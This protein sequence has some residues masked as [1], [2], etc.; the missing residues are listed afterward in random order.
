LYNYKTIEEKSSEWGITQRHIQ[1][2][3]RKGLIA[4]AI[5]RAGAW[6]IPDETP[7][8]VKNTRAGDKPFMFVGTK[9]LIFNSSI[10]L[11]T[12]KG[13]EN[14]SMN[15]ITAAIGVRQSAVYNHFKSKHE[16]LDTIYDFFKY[17]YMAS[18]PNYADVESLFRTDS[19][20]DVIINGF[21]Y[22]FDEEARPQMVDIAKLIMQ[23]AVI[24]ATAANLCRSLLLEEGIKFVEDCLNMAA[25]IGRIAP[26]DAHTMSLLINSI[27]LQTLIWVIL[28]PP[29]EDIVR[30]LEDEKKLFMYIAGIL[31]DLKPPATR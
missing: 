10:R 26:V 18:R 14:V 24:D 7:S 19:L 12:Q 16:I 22:E 21:V 1:N 11:F 20:Y 9:K 2:L 13:Y 3:C 5:K 17:N 31:T 15:D 29:P 4:G 23:R 30:R 27:R 6:F 25:D 8:P 28:N